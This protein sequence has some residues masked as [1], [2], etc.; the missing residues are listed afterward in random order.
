[1]R[2]PVIQGPA[3]RSARIIFGAAKGRKR[4]KAVIFS[5]PSRAHAAEL[6]ARAGLMTLKLSRSVLRRVPDQLLEGDIHATGQLHLHPIPRDMFGALRVQFA[7]QAD[8]PAKGAS[9]EAAGF[10]AKATQQRIASTGCAQAAI[11]TAGARPIAGGVSPDRCCR[12]L[13]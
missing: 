12:G 10:T 6:V 3:R 9:G 4:P 5:D 8:K 13:A 11:G 7:S 1:M 2:R